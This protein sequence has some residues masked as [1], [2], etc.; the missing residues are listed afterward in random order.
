MKKDIKDSKPKDKTCCWCLEREMGVYVLGIIQI[1]YVCTEVGG[2]I[3]FASN[4]IN[5]TVKLVVYMGVAALFKFPEWIAGYWY[6]R[7]FVKK[8]ENPEFKDQL[9]RAHLLNIISIIFS[10][11]WAIIG[12]YIMFDTSMYTH[13]GMG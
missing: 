13:G 11:L 9:P 5:L 6:L 3:Y 2:A 7:F 4:A 10:T 12:G 8:N 1:I